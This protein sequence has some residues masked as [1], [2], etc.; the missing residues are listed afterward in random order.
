MSGLKLMLYLFGDGGQLMLMMMVNVGIIV[1]LSRDL[2]DWVS[3]RLCFAFGGTDMS[4]SWTSVYSLIRRT[5]GED[6][7]CTHVN[8][9]R[10]FFLY[11]NSNLQ[12]DLSLDYKPSS[13]ANCAIGSPLMMMKL[14][15]LI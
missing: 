2:M 15:S 11:R 12:P 10:K 7:V 14:K 8:S 4:V 5:W 6:G 13:L 1:Q 3:Q 9:R